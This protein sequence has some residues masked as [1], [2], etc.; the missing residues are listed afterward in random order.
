M[1]PQPT[2]RLAPPDA[3]TQAFFAPTL[4]CAV[5]AAPIAK[6]PSP[7]AC[8]ADFELLPEPRRYRFASPLHTSD[9]E[10]EEEDEEEE[11][12]EEEEEEEMIKKKEND[13]NSRMR[14]G[15]ER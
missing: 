1:P 6:R 8:A 10:E 2:V 14:N 11:D 4:L 3:A 9:E 15:R 7:T 5:R 13:E 12:E